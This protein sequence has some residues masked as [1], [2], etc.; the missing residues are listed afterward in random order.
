M[1]IDEGSASSIPGTPK[2]PH[3]AFRAWPDV[4]FPLVD[5]GFQGRI[6]L[7]WAAIAA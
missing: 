5:K 4:M 1:G 3:I 6:D 7:G 2:V